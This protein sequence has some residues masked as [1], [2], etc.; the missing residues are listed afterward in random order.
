MYAR[1]ALEADTSVLGDEAQFAYEPAPLDFSPR[2]EPVPQT[3][4]EIAVAAAASST[5]D[6]DRAIDRPF[7][8]A[9]AFSQRMM[10]PTE[11]EIAG[12]SATTLL[13][14]RTLGSPRS[15]VSTAGIRQSSA[16]RIVYL[17]DASGSMIGA[18][19]TA[20]HEVVQS[21]ARLSDEQSFAVVVFQRGEA[22][23]AQSE[24]LRSAGTRFGAAEIDG[25]RKWLLDAI[26][27]SGGSDVSKALQVAI[28]M[29][30]DTIVI[31]SAGLMGAEKLEVDRD[32]L[33]LE[34]DRLN[35]RNRRTGRRL[36]QIGCI[37]FM[38][39]EPLRVLEMIARDHGGRGAYRYVPRLAELQSP[40]KSTDPQDE[41]TEQVERALAALKAG[42]IVNARVQLIR[43]GLG[44]PNHPAS[45]LA[46]TSAAEVYLL[47]DHDSWTALRLA[48]A[49]IR[50]ARAFELESVVKRAEVVI[51]LAQESSPPPTRTP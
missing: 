50:S 18:Y 19:P 24:Q 1:H 26:V 45:P 10:S 31:A 8:E 9:R 17:L 35:P 12:L 21:I 33:L 38:D 16:T 20:V 49:A 11:G 3:Q 23:L 41:E 7:V 14:S 47:N 46:L 13:A 15:S 32:A 40:M 22:F 29:R 44:A 48:D 4:E 28:A 42:D 30:P 27:P 39:P 51:R 5:R 43:I 2:A 6:G 37:H 25:L 34:F 36:V